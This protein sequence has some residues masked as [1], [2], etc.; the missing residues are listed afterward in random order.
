MGRFT[1]KDG[2]EW[3]LTLDAPKIMEVRRDCDP[4]FL[5]ESDGAESTTFVRL[6]DDP[7]LLCRV[8]YVL[9]N[10]QRQR[11]KVSEEEFYLGVVG[12]VIDA[13]T[14]ALL[15]AMLSFIPRRRRE[16]L[17]ATAAQI[18]A[19]QQLATTQALRK[20]QDPE[21]EAR[22]LAQLEN[23]MDAAIGAALTLRRS[24]SS[25]QASAESIPAA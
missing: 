14:E 24:A 18:Q 2:R 10:K 20:L 8:L 12:N 1:D 4:L 21:L 16:A 6:S 7:V 11:L 3:E 15:Q 25:L 17:E 22:V 13:A 5:K 23:D 9:C 19:I